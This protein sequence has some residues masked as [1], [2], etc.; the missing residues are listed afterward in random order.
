MK[1]LN[2]T[3]TR[4]GKLNAKHRELLD[5]QAK[6]QARLAKTRERFNEGYRDA[7]DV[8]NNLEWTQKK[9]SYVACPFFSNVRDRSLGEFRSASDLEIRRLAG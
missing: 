6:A 7:Q 8:R 5:L 1:E 2:L 3:R 4:S 9:V